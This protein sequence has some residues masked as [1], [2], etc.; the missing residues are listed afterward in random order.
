MRPQTITSFD[1]YKSEY[2]KSIENPEEFW[3]TYAKTFL[4][5]EKWDEVNSGSLEDGNIKWFEGGKL[6]IT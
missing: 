3:G 2:Q 6:N 5:H 4:W 1:E